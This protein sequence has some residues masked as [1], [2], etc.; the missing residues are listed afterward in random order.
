MMQTSAH[1]QDRKGSSDTRG[2]KATASKEPTTTSQLHKEGDKEQRNRPRPPNC[3]R[4]GERDRRLLNKAPSQR[5]RP[6]QEMSNRSITVTLS[7][8]VTKIRRPTNLMRT[9]VV[10]VIAIEFRQLYTQAKEVRKSL[11]GI[12]ATPA[13]RG[14]K[15][16]A[17]KRD[18]ETTWR[19]EIHREGR[20]LKG[21]RGGDEDRDHFRDQDYCGE[22]HPHHQRR[23]DDEDDS[24]YHGDGR[25]HRQ[26]D[27]VS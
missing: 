3:T 24:R 14:V 15:K 1:D 9:V 22:T 27:S 18:E 8:K 17:S 2:T 13:A 25:R 21:K 12:R 16:K 10:T 11:G 5:L 26:E 23:R 6:A 7:M 19:H 4:K 20:P